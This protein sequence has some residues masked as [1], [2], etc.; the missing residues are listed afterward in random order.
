VE[1]INLFTGVCAGLFHIMWT[2][3]NYRILWYLH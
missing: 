3:P 2:S 1:V